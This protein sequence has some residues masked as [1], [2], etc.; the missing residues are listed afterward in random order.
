MKEKTKN[1]NL[2]VVVIPAIIANTVWLIP[3]I[4]QILASGYSH[5]LLTQKKIKNCFFSFPFWVV[6]LFYRLER[7]DVTDYA[8]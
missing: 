1:A 8:T 7:G 6:S 5:L 3:L 2:S 4:N